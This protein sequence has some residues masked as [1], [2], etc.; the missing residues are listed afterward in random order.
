MET[1]HCNFCGSLHNHQQ[2]IDYLY[3]Y[4]GKYLLVPNMPVE[5]CDECG[6][7]Y[8]QATV[9]QEI[10]RRFFAIQDKKETPDRYITLPE[11]AY[12]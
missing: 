11:M 7:I 4:Q 2:H 12:A 5:I 3:S 10:E 1:K 9:L 8:Y 6:M